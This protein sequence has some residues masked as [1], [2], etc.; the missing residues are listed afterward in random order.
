MISWLMEKDTLLI[1]IKAIV[2]THEGLDI[3]GVTSANAL[4][5]ADHF[6]LLF[7]SYI[8]EAG[9]MPEWVWQS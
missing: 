9:S 7:T 8:A 6:R 3:V 5:A 2:H 4:H 1:T